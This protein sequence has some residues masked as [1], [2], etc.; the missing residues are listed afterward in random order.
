MII[1]TDIDYNRAAKLRVRKENAI[2]YGL[3]SQDIKKIELPAMRTKH[4]L[5]DIL[6][7]KKYFRKHKPPTLIALHKICQ[8]IKD[9]DVFIEVLKT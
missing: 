1:N 3:S 4:S 8:L 2:R 5:K 9:T 6:L 7:W